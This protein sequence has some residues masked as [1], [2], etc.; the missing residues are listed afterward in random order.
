ML[1]SFLVIGDEILKGQVTDTNSSFLA[2]EFRQLGLLLKKVTTI[3]FYLNN[4]IFSINV[5]IIYRFQL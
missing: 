5:L 1:I 2:K 3:Y 4:K